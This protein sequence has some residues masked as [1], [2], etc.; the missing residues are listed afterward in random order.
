MRG[1]LLKPRPVLGLFDIT[2]LV[3]GAVVGA[4]IYVVASLGAAFLGPAVLVVWVIGGVLAALIALSFVQSAVIVPRAGGP[5]AYVRRAFGEFPAFMVGWALYVGEWFSL[6]V[7]PIAFVRYLS[8]FVPVIPPLGVILIK[9]A[10]VAFLTGS[11]IIGTRVG[12]RV[13][14]VLT[15]AKLTPLLVLIITGLVAVLA[16]PSKAADNLTPFVPFGWAG[17]SPALIQVFWAYAGFELATLPAAEVVEPRRTLPRAFFIGMAVVTVFYL[18]VNL[19]VVS[20][21]PTPVIAE[22][23]IPLV[24]SISAILQILGLPTVVGSTLMALGGLLSISGVEEAFNLGTSRLSYAMAVDGLFPRFFAKLHPHFGTPYLGLLFLGGTSLL[25]SIIGNLNG[26]ITISIFGLSVAYIATGLAAVRLC[27]QN[28]HQRLQFPGASVILLAAVGASLFLLSQ[29][30]YL[31][32]A[33]GIPLVLVGIPIYFL[34]AP[35]Q[36][37]VGER[38]ELLSRARQLSEAGR[39]GGS[40]FA[41]LIRL[42]ARAIG[43]LARRGEPR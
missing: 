32:F 7:F 33:L 42:V 38:D 34:V 13:N 17:F 9:V 21:V 43:L 27:R 3:I 11:N 4:D 31:G 29:V 19:V 6:A 41:G 15:L 23:K 1:L 37:L 8:F 10:F 30:G 22:S 16:V 2:N 14:D 40:S 5:Y 25:A 24:T 20:S 36:V 35:R 26:L 18:T 39:I 12:G 28:P